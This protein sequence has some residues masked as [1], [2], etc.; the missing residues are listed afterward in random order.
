MKIEFDPYERS[1][2]VFIESDDDMTIF[3]RY[4]RSEKLP[5]HTIISYQFKDGNNMNFY[6]VYEIED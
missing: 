3:T 2:E 1:L 4:V 6:K 5:N